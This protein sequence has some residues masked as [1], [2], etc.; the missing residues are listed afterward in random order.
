MIEIR[1]TD[2][3]KNGLLRLK[4]EMQEHVLMF[5]SEEYHWE[6]LAMETCWRRS[7]RNQDRLRTWIPPIFSPEEKYHNHSDLRW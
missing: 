6:I 7:I 1:Q 5:V 3:Y 2:I 4:T